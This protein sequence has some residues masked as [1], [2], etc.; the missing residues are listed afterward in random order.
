MPR[1]L[2]TLRDMAAG[3]RSD[4]G[5]D[6]CKSV[7]VCRRTGEGCEYLLAVADRHN[8]LAILHG[9]DYVQQ[10]NLFKNHARL[11]HGRRFEFKALL[12]D[13]ARLGVEKIEED[14]PCVQKI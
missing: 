14:L 8:G 13:P 4:R 7:Q 12:D 10:L 9:E 5:F 11:Q 3:C 6:V 1:Y 2:S